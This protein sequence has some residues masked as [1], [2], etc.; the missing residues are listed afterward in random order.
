MSNL[1]LEVALRA[2]GIEFR[3]ANVGDR[4]VL[5]MLKEHGGVI[6]GESSGHILCLDRTTT[7]DALI[8]ALQVLAVMRSTGRTLAELSADMPRFPQI[9]INVRVATRFDPFG[10]PAV[11]EAV[12]R[13]EQRLGGEGRVVLRASGTEPVIR[14]MVE[15]REEAETR[16]CAD[17][18]VR[19]VQAA[20]T[21]LST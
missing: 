7:G 4:H 17:E 19:A 8:A 14:V 10:I 11:C 1:G 5:T 15:G 16:S 18:I 6:G 9:L 3:R 13:V 12:S 2:K 20:S 21:N